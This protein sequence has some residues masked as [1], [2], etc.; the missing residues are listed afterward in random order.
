[1]SINKETWKKIKAEYEAGFFTEDVIFSKLGQNNNVDRSTISKKAK[2]EGWIY[3]K[4]SHIVNLDI[5][6]IREISQS[7]VEKS[8]L[9]REELKAIEDLKQIELIK[10]GLKPKE[11]KI[12][13]MAYNTILQALKINQDAMN[14]SEVEFEDTLKIVQ[15]AKL[16]K[17]SIQ[18]KQLPNQVIN[19]TNATQNNTTLTAEEISIAIAK[20]LPN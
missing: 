15:T 18:E 16:A 1:M 14:N 12:C 2:K 17:E 19:N 7:N 3:G 6:A 9:S 20:G 11:I 13:D 4:N 10:Q 8:H 5:S